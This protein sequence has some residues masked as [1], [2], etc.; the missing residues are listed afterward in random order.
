VSETIIWHGVMPPHGDPTS[1]DRFPVTIQATEQVP[2][3]VATIL[4]SAPDPAFSGVIPE[5]MQ[6]GATEEEEYPD[7][8]SLYWSLIEDYGFNPSIK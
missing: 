8:E 4:F 2:K 3:W 7:S 6:I 5:I 1:H